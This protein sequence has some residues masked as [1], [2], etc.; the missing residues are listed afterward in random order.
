MFA[1]FGD[2]GNTNSGYNIPAGFSLVPNE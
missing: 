1:G 2:S